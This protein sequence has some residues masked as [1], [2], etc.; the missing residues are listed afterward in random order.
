MT[1]P[2]VRQLPPPP[3]LRPWSRIWRYLLA[4]GLALVAWITVVDDLLPDEPAAAVPDVVNGVIVLDLFLGVVALALLPLRRRYPVLVASGTVALS[5]ASAAAFGASVLAAVSMAT[6]RRVRGV[7]VVGAFWL[8]ATLVYETMYGR[9]FEATGVDYPA[10][11]SWVGGGLVLAVYG[12]CVATGFY[13]GARRELVANLHERA[14]TA[15]REQALRAEAAREAERTRIAREMH[16]VL[17][18]RISLVAMHAGAVAYRTDLSREET[19]R[20][21]GIIQDNAHLALTELRQV[22]GV[23]RSDDGAA[24]SR[25]G[26]ASLRG[27][28]A[29]LQ[30]GATSG[31]GS[32]NGGTSAERPVEPPQPTLAQLDV[33]VTETTGTGSAV[34]LDVSGLPGGDA[35]ALAELPVTTSRT[36]YRI[37]QEA[38]TNTRK[39]AR[40]VPVDVRLGGGPG[41]LLTIEV[42]N[43]SAIAAATARAGTP[44]AVAAPPG[45]GVGLTG[46]TERAH[47]VGGVL[48]HGFEEDGS[49]AV[50]AWLPWEDE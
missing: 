5:A 4:G 14:V 16:D 41:G 12:I 38:L 43:A 13:V 29:S 21:A 20:A 31:E 24:S 47:L 37:L 34:R 39:H 40:G 18:H 8:A 11:Y 35:A 19:T 23:L 42:Q 22:L 46:L 27:G 15:E 32:S 25:D 28:A 9:T 2:A 10:V 3:R 17:A 6:R 30:G 36:A 33:L 7:L 1:T 49:F 44:L 45:A 26:A 50:R 48:E